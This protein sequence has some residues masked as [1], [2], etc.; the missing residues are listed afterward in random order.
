MSRATS[1]TSWVGAGRMRR[2]AI[3]AAAVGCVMMWV[4]SVM[5]WAHEL[6]RAG[7]SANVQGLDHGGF[8]ILTLALVGNG[9]V[10]VRARAGLALVGLV[11]TAWLVI[12]LYELPGVLTDGAAYE[13]ALAWGAY[14]ALGGAVTVVAAAAAA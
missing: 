1:L 10:W 12:C 13:A 11:A 9:M 14:L 4:G 6:L 3:G 5:P 2:G 7:G 8:V